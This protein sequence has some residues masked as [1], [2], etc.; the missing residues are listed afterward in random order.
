MKLQAIQANGKSD[1]VESLINAATALGKL[2][3]LFKNIPV[4]D[5]D[6]ES[7]CLSERK[8]ASAWYAC[9]VNSNIDPLLIPEYLESRVSRNILIKKETEQYFRSLEQFSETRF[10]DE[11]SLYENILFR[12]NRPQKQKD[13]FDLFSTQKESDQVICPDSLI[14][15]FQ[16]WNTV[17]EK[18]DGL[19]DIMHRFEEWFRHTGSRFSGQRQLVMWL[20]YRLWK[21]Y[22]NISFR[23]KTEEFL[24]KISGSDR[25]DKIQLIPALAEHFIQQ[26]E[27]IKTELKMMYRKITGWEQMN[28][29]Q[30]LLSGHLFES[31]FRFGLQEPELISNNG[32]F[33]L[34]CQKGCIGIDDVSRKEQEAEVYNELK[35]LIGS[36]LAELAEE[37]GG[38]MLQL[39]IENDR[40][41]SVLTNYRNISYPD[42]EIKI[43]TFLRQEPVRQ[44]VSLTGKT[45]ASEQ[46][47]T[48][49]SQTQ[50]RKKAFFG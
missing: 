3:E 36:G 10:E 41:K 1:S 48:V 22:G 50:I 20:N 4:S 23:L 29:R 45:S 19:Q 25:P 16:S 46:E 2:Y 27:N 26:S 12:E 40:G 24:F 31:A 21:L 28:S 38:I 8:N 47:A 11:K 18:E 39:R 32:I 14:E 43:E 42:R 6:K 13:S 9:L 44:I 17:S 49:K 33:R 15:M 34:L 7:F 5:E 37:G 30:K 35:L